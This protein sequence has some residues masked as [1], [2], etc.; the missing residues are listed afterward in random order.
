M[1]VKSNIQYQ[2]LA[3][4]ICVI[5]HGSV[6]YVCVCPVIEQGSVIYVDVSCHRTWQCV[7]Y[8][9][10]CPVIEHGSV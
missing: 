7:I 5:E 6:I 8:V 4:D 3:Y 10:V 2:P 9:G 1:T